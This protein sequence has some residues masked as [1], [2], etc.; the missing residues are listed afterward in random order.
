LHQIRH[1]LGGFRGGDDVLGGFVPRNI[2]VHVAEV[3]I[4]QDRF[5]IAA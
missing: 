5:D 4:A 2:E 3:G 1:R